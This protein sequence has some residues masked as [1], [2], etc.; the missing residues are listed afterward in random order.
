MNADI[1]ARP[2]PA[3]LSLR[4]NFA[5]TLAGNIIYAGCQWGMLVTLARLGSPGMVGQF[6][7]GLAVCAPV[8]ALSNL[9]L[10]AIQATDASRFHPFAD[11][12]SLRF[13]ATAVA[14]L[15]IGGI[16]AAR[17]HKP[18]DLPVILLIGLA[19][20]FEALSDIYHGLF[21]QHE[22]MNRIAISLIAKGVFSVIALALG[23]LLTQSLIVG[24]AG[25]TF[26]WGIVLGCYDMLQGSRIV[27]AATQPN[28][29]ADWQ[30]I[31]PL[32]LM[33]L[34]MGV[35]VFINSL[36]INLPRYYLDYFHDI[37]TLGYFAAISYIPIAAGFVTGALGQAAQPRI[38]ALY[39]DR[40]PSLPRITHGLASVLFVFGALLAAILFVAGGPILGALYGSTYASFVTP[41]GVLMLGA[42]FG[43]AF[44]FYFSLLIAA[45]AFRQLLI[46]QAA[47]LL[48]CFA[49][50]T[51]V[52]ADPIMTA[53]WAAAAGEAGRFGVSVLFAV[54]VLH[55]D[56]TS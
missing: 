29:D 47:G 20:A 18:E 6:A 42:S 21:Q 26:V 23:V 19:K 49:V 51:M 25:M 22:Q 17:G 3:A 53:A 30:R 52:N 13:A 31:R 40:A 38:A 9:N 16:V 28:T 10:R 35:M 55:A 24:I 2:T 48:S 15:V 39:R 34:P 32:L 8:I 27:A 41:L 43:Y 44:H 14:L 7:L 33:S 46:A 56:S 4:H 11:Y 36:T 12:W 45:R 37:A 5:W 1:E 50:L 54:V